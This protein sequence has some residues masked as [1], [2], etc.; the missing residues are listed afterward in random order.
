MKIYF[1]WDTVNN[2]IVTSTGHRSGIYTSLVSVVF[3]FTNLSWTNR[4]S[5]QFIIKAAD[6]VNERVLDV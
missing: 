3:A 6:L 4:N 2:R 1:I 5:K